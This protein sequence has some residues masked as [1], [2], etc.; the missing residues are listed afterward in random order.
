MSCEI[1]RIGQKKVHNIGDF[2]SSAANA[3]YIHDSDIYVGGV[4][5]VITFKVIEDIDYPSDTEADYEFK[6]FPGY[7]KN[8]IWYSLSSP[9]NEYVPIISDITNFGDDIYI[10]GYFD[11]SQ[12]QRDYR[13]KTEYPGYWKNDTWNDLSFP[14]NYLNA[15]VVSVNVVDG[16][17]VI[18]GNCS[19]K[20]EYLNGSGSIQKKVAGYWIDGEWQELPPISTE[21]CSVVT[22][23]I[24]SNGKYFAGGYCEYIE[25]DSDSSIIPGYWENGKWNRI[26]EDSEGKVL[27]LMISENTIYAGGSFQFKDSDRYTNCVYWVDGV[28]T[29]LFGDPHSGTAYGINYITI[30]GNDLYT[31]AFKYD[32]YSQY[33]GFWKNGIWIEY[34]IPEIS[35]DSYTNIYP[36]IN[37]ALLNESILYISGSLLN[38]SSDAYLKRP[39]LLHLAGIWKNNEWN[40]LPLPAFCNDFINVFN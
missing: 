11:S 38:V 32:Y 33:Q 20:N 4:I 29:P 34:N 26:S 31:I 3:I 19:L 7:W 14:D 2:V 10:V 24:V 25:S 9:D 23:A 6:Y 8:N 30:S 27:S 13:L 40:Q 18:S 17:I 16:K 22:T 5:E 35:H 21:Y 37:K 1:M 39:I 15:N 12:I 28:L 36:D